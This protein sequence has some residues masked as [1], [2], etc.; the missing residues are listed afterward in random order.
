MSDWRPPAGPDGFE[1]ARREALAEAGL[2]HLERFRTAA[3]EYLDAEAAVAELIRDAGGGV[4]VVSQR[5]GVGAKA[6]GWTP[7]LV[8][9]G[10]RWIDALERTF[11]AAL[12]RRSSLP[13]ERRRA[14]VE[15][16]VP[17]DRLDEMPWPSTPTLCERVEEAR[18][19]ALAME[20]AVP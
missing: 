1:R 9:A 16:G 10:R 20:D 12:E 15:A 13:P 3:R 17:P 7:E 11:E 14:L 19:L 5:T 18:E 6:R 4:P 8:D 2:E